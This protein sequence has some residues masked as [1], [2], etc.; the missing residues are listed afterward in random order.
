M[1]ESTAPVIR[2]GDR[3]GS[4]QKAIRISDNFGLLGWQEP[5]SAP[6]AGLALSVE[7]AAAVLLLA[8]TALMVM[9][10]GKGIWPGGLGKAK[11]AA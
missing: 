2:R 8:S 11:L 7:L 9:A 3:N 4:R 1:A 6:Y 10:V 5:V